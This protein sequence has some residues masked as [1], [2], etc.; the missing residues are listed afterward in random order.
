MISSIKDFIYSLYNEDGSFSFSSENTVANLYSTCFGVMSLSSIGQ[1]KSF[2]HKDKVVRF[3]RAHQNHKSGYFEDKT[4][5]VSEDALHNG[6]YV[7]WQLT[8]FSTMA[9]NELGEKPKCLFNFLV[10]Y[11]NV[12]Y[13]TSW[14]YSLDWSNPWLISNSVMF[15]LNIL[16]LEDEISNQEYIDFLIDLLDQV[17]EDRTG[18]W[19]LSKKP[20]LHNKMA[21]AYHFMIFYTYCSRKIKNLQ[22]IIDSTT[23][24]ADSNGL[25]SNFNGGGSCDDLDGVDILCRAS[26]YTWYSIEAI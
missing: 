26:L 12:E 15:L 19:G 17:Q 9:L 13:L 14:F 20:S 10:P 5:N 16:I 23:L 24:L 11:K 25:F 3:I 1:L 4:L 18:F 7:L 2:P 21:A 8:D 22:Q 6:D